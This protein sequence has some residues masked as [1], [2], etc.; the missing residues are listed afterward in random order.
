M[1]S[2]RK[3]TDCDFAASAD[4]T[5]ILVDANGELKKLPA[6]AVGGGGST[7]GEEIVDKVERMYMLAVMC[8]E[9][10]W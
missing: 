6:S 8:A 1:E 9:R 4:G 2:K 3:I 7:G 5:N 10:E